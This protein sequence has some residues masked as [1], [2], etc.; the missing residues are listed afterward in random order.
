MN[1]FE[2]VESWPSPILLYCP[3]VPLQ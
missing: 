2:S 3:N 1:R